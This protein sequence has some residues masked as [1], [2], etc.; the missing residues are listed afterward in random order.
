[1]HRSQFLT[2]FTFFFMLAATLAAQVTPLE[3]EF[4]LFASGFNDPVGLYH[5]GDDRLFVLEQDDGHIEL[6]DADGNTLGT[7]LDVGNLISTGSER[8]LLGLAFAPDYQSS[9]TFYINYT[10]NGG[11]TVIARYQVDGND[12]NVADAGSAEIILTIDQP[13]GNHNGGHIAFGADGY[14]YIGMGDGGSAGDPLNLSQNPTSL[15]GKMLRVDVD[16]AEGYSIPPDNPY[17]N[18]PG[19]ENEIWAIGVRN[20]WKFSFDRQTGDLWIGD[21]GQGEWE[22]IHFQDAGSDGGE[23]YGWRC[24]EGPDPY[25]TS[26]CLPES[27]YVFPVASISHNS[28]DNWCSVTGGI[29]YRGSTYPAMQGK[30]FFTDYC[31]GD[32]YALTAEGEGNFSSDLLV[33]NRGFGYVAFGEDAGGELYAV[34]LNGNIEKIVDSCGPFNPTIDAANGALEASSGVAYSWFLNGLE[35]QGETGASFEPQASGNVYALVENQDGCVRQTNS[36]DW[37][38]V[39][40]VPGCTYPSAENYNVEAAVDDGTCTFSIDT[41]PGDFDND[42]VVGTNDLLGFLTAF[43]TTCN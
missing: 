42:A 40:G 12:P 30:Y 24:Y 38:T 31:V 18:D 32:F 22:E 25:N 7:F 9:G 43:G 39:S 2:A 36:L 11:D 29:V 33:N 5:C 17:V 19:I 20:P 1:M 23:N 6:L 3:I 4:E 34:R 21:V 41:C 37:I 35:V 14:L 13:F 8:G 26:G 27:E 28:P 16:Q 15:L 10:N